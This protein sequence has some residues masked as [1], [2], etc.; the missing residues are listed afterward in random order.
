MQF[1]PGVTIEASGDKGAYD[2]AEANQWTTFQDF[3][4]SHW[5]NSLIWGEGIENVSI[6]EPGLISGKA[7]GRGDAREIGDNAIALELC[8]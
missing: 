4:H 3:G 6:V 8:R 5:H 2:E 1:E 7:L